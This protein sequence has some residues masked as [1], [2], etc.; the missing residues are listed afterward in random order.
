MI[1]QS[2]PWAYTQKNTKALIQKDTCTPTFTALVTV[3]KAWKQPKYPSTEEWIE[4]TWYI[5]T[6]DSAIKRTK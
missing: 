5:Y 1:P 2:H 6:M 3:A 4:K